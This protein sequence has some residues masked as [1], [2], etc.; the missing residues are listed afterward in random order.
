MLDTRDLPTR[1]LEIGT[2]EKDL[3]S[4]TTGSV[5]IFVGDCPC[6]WLSFLESGRQGTLNVDRYAQT[7]DCSV[8]QG[9]SIDLVRITGGT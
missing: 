4:F 2:S 7:D 1:A 9:R 6:E 8:F 5:E 3:G